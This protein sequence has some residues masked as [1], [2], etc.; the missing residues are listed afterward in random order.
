[1]G[2]KRD[3]AFGLTSFVRRDVREV[4]L[5]IHTG[6]NAEKSIGLL[7]SAQFLPET[8]VVRLDAEAPLGIECDPLLIGHQ[9]DAFAMGAVGQ[10]A[11]CLN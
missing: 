11:C 4:L 3:F 7:N 10:L 2:Q 6:V 1:M 9:E 8:I 5:Q